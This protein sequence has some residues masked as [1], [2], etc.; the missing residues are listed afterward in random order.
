MSP[1]FNPETFILEGL[2]NSR[3]VKV[4][5]SLLFLKAYAHINGTK[6]WKKFLFFLRN[7][8]YYIIIVKVKQK[9]Y[10]S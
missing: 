1:L 4:F 3:D 8:L 9:M 5:A 6:M 2:F 10:A 7:I